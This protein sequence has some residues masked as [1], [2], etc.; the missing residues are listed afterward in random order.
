MIEHGE[1]RLPEIQ[2][3]YIRR[4]PSRARR[5]GLRSASSSLEHPPNWSCLRQKR[6]QPTFVRSED[7]MADVV[8]VVS[9][10]RQVLSQ[11]VV[12]VEVLE[13]R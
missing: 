10:A 13:V 7:G 11:N 12:E 4:S 6:L 5:K 2:R 8:G 3:R 9:V 1:L